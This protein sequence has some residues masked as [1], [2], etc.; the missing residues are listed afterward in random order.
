MKKKILII[1]DQIEGLCRVGWKGRVIGG[2]GGIVVVEVEPLEEI[3]EASGFV[4]PEEPEME[5]EGW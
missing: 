4:A 1:Q 3:Y 5:P 2:K